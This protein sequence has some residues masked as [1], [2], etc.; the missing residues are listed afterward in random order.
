MA[1]DALISWRAP[2]HFHTQKTSDWYWAVGIITLALTAV[3]LMFGQIITGIFIVVAATALVIHASHPPE[4][5][6]Y[7]INDRG[8]VVGDILYPFL[9][10]ESFYI[11]HDHF[12]PK[13]LVKARKLFMPLMAIYILD[14]DPEEVREILLRYIAE[15]THHEPLL[16]YLLERFGF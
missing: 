5:I 2:A 8:L 9:S 15:T 1:T 13:L 16:K 12:P 11:P 7:E 10:L 3:A 6:Y 14:T 4:E